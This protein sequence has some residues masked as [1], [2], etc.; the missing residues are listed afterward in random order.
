MNN[1]N[2][3]NVMKKAKYGNRSYTKQVLAQIL[4]Q[5]REDEIADIIIECICQGISNSLPLTSV[6]RK[7]ANR[8]YRAMDIEAE[9]EDRITIRLGADAIDWAA[10]AGLVEADKFSTGEADGQEQY[11]LMPTCEELVNYIKSQELPSLKADNGETP[12]TGPVLRVGEYKLDIVKS[13]RR[14]G[15]LSNYRQSKMPDV[16]SALNKLHSTEW[17]INKLMLNVLSEA[18][19]C[20]QNHLR[21]IPQEITELE[22]R[23]SLAVINNSERTALW[24]SEIKFKQLME[25]GYDEG[26]AE[27]ISN[28]DAC[29]WKM[30]KQFDHLEV[31][32]TWSKRMD[33]E[34]CLRLAT[35]YGD[36]ILN[37]IYNCD[38]RGRVYAVQ[39]G[40][41]P[42]GAD[43][44]KALL[45]F[46]NPKQISTY[47]FKI[48]LANH[49]GEDKLSYDDRIQWVDT[50]ADALYL[51]GSD[52]WNNDAQAFFLQLN[53]KGEIKGPAKEKKS[54]WQFIAACMEFARLVDYVEAHGTD[55]GFLCVIP[56]AYDATNS[57]LQI[58]SALGR[59]EVIAPLV[60]ITA[61]EKPGDVY[62][63]IGDYV[64]KAHSI[65]SLE[66]FSAGEKVWRKICK[67]NVMTKSYAATRTGMGDQQW[68]DRKEHGNDAVANLTVKEC[69]DLGALVYDT[70]SSRLLRASDL[71]ETMKKAVKTVTKSTVQWSLPSGFTAFQVKDKS[72]KTDAR[73][74][75]GSN[76]NIRL[77]FYTFTDVPNKI[78]HANAIAPDIVHSF[79]AWL[80]MSIVNSM[81]TTSNLAFVHDQFGS[82]SIHGADIQDI[83]RVC[84]EIICSRTVL[85]TVLWEVA[86]EPVELPEAGN[87]DL[88]EVRNAE[89]IVC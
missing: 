47:D 26:A 80:L 29:E 55:E 57:G 37:F 44:A 79:D 31:I 36:S 61:T 88:K 75:I 71:M 82:D 52:F 11:F 60:N 33:L 22:R 14:Y 23:S 49:A 34:R 20:T 65:P 28:R 70:C 74:R 17:I 4:E 73:V 43:F 59:D 13:A 10:Q 64:A 78:K 21:Y 16:Y 15:L 86:G 39:H 56:V 25:L 63:Y 51:L 38:S 67:R 54:R 41:N 83:A 42:Q 87:W 40:L 66:A 6:C 48:T 5:G 50:N 2:V 1:E 12:W 30:K 84:Y 81:P 19:G 58:L 53:D 24:I 18:V 3:I 76:D 69:R 27:G 46:A 89:Y 85:E 77:V 45:Q 62:Q 8:I 72:K 68:E 9:Q 7:T 35:N 32:S